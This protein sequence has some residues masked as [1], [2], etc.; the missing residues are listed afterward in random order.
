MLELAAAFI[1]FTSLLTYL[2]YRFVGLPPTIGVM[3]IALIFSVGLQGLS[4]LGFPD[5]E[6]HIGEL[7]GQIDFNDLLM[8]W[9]LGFLLFAGA[10]HVSLKDLRDYKWAIGSLA[11]FGVL[12]S[13][14]LIG[15][16]T[17]WI[18]DWLGWHVSLLYCLIFGALIS[19]TDPI[20]VLGILRSAGAPKSLETT[21]VGEALF[22]DG[23][24]V[25]VYSVLLGVIQLGE[26]PTVNAALWL[27]LEE[28][29]GGILFG[30][31]IGFVC[32]WLMLSI[33]QHQIEVMLSLALVIGGS[34]LASHLHVSGPIAMVVAGLIIG[35]L[36]RTKAMND[37]T[38]RYLDGF[39]ELID[40]I[41]N[42]LLFALIG[43]ELLVLPFTWTHLGAALLVTLAILFAR[44]ISVVPVVLLSP[45]W[46]NMTRGTARILTWGALRGGVSVAL[47]LSL[48]PGP[49][50][51]L[52]LALTYIVV[53][54]S[55]LGQ[56]LT[57]GRV[58]K[59]VTG[60]APVAPKDPH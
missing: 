51:N 52:I 36:G 18:F 16:F 41:L 30:L 47:A 42:A 28:A 9:M 10:L 4:W 22:N 49:E 8:N 57:I 27:F 29:G 31:L 33:E 3:V 25:V 35:N 60:G 13:T 56:G 12:I 40:E 50:R 24:A 15:Y 21:I 5:L 20:A 11:T 44:W 54:V 23:V 43:M 7:L 39:W 2:N 37:F 6:R 59:G 48:P 19:P 38:R 14:V 45:H 17:Y 1:C 55:I 46:R 58:V 26:T 34:T 53:L 32:Y